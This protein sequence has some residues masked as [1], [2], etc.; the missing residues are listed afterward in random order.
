MLAAAISTSADPARG[1]ET[2]SEETKQAVAT[3]VDRAIV[4]GC[5]DDV[6][7]LLSGLSRGGSFVDDLLLDRGYILRLLV[8]RLR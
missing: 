1:P 4:D 5:L 3:V 7:R 8:K 2:S 6:D